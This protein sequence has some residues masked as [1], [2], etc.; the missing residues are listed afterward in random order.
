MVELAGMGVRMASGAAGVRDPVD[1]C[2]GLW[3]VTLIATHRGVSAVQ[4]ISALAMLRGVEGGRFESF[5]PVA[6]RAL[7]AVSSVGELILMRTRPV[8]IRAPV[9]GDWLF[10]I[11]L[12]VARL[13]RQR[14]VL[15]L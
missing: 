9:M 15:S 5:D 13:A 2:C 14:G 4:R 7:A 6:R 10:E 3:L 1:R 11:A 8:A 12:L